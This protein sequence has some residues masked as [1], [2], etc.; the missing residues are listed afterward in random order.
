MSFIQLKYHQDKNLEYD[1]SDI[2]HIYNQY[3]TSQTI[4]DFSGNTYLNFFELM[5]Y[6]NTD[7]TNKSLLEQLSL[8]MSSSSNDKIIILYDTTI[9]KS[10]QSKNLNNSSPSYTFLFN[11]I[12]KIL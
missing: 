8:N 4:L 9:N 11:L 5:R 3:D 6:F 10:S 1:W 12:M 7:T 2:K